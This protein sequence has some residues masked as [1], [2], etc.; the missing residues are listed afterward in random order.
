MDR[1]FSKRVNQT[2]YFPPSCFDQKPTR[3]VMEDNN[4]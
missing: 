3:K 1:A 2:V 4:K